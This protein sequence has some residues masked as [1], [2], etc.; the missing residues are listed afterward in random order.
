MFRFWA[1]F[2][3]SDGDAKAIY[4]ITLHGQTGVHVT[5]CLPR[6]RELEAEGEVLDVRRQDQD[7]REQQ[8][9]PEQISQGLGKQ[10]EGTHRPEEEH[11]MRGVVRGYYICGVY[12]CFVLD[13]SSFSL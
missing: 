12:I 9:I 10:P 5:F 11:G 7:P 3:L 4:H 8:G 1:D 6:R 2:F 13:S